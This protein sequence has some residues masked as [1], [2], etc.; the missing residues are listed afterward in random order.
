MEQF[1]KIISDR[2]HILKK[3]AALRAIEMELAQTRDEIA[4]AIRRGKFVLPKEA[5]AHMGKISRGE[6]HKGFPF[7][8]LDFPKHFSRSSVFALRTLFWW[9]NPFI[10]TFHL[11]G[12]MLN[13]HRQSLA[14]NISTLRGKSFY[15]CVN[16]RE[17]DHAI[18]KRNYRR[19]DAIKEAELKRMIAERPFIKLARQLPLKD[20]RKLKKF[21]AETFISV[22]SC[23]DAPRHPAP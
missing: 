8:V 13:G 23:L 4:K 15:F 7:V 22:Y 10:V 11:G 18:E 3:T 12:E 17:W 19:L 1:L 16:D 9:G 2:D 6:N 21:A 14:K 5:D 20:V